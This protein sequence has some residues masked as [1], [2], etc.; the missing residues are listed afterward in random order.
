MSICTSLG[1]SAPAKSLVMQEVGARIFRGGTLIKQLE[2]V[3]CIHDA[4]S[5]LCMHQQC[6]RNA[7]LAAISQFKIE[8]VIEFAVMSTI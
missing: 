8:S 7:R 1:S 4:P 5:S 3:K 6:K 2:Q